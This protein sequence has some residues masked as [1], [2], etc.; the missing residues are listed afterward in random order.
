MLTKMSLS[1]HHFKEAKMPAN[2]HT[3][4]V[5]GLTGKKV[6]ASNRKSLQVQAGKQ[7]L[8]I[9]LAKLEEEAEVPATC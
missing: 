5:H 6:N 2:N 1:W 4:L 7:S 9:F 8:A 3:F